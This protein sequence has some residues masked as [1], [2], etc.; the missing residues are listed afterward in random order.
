MNE[1]DVTI[2]VADVQENT[3]HL[4]ETTMQQAA[5]SRAIVKNLN[6]KR[7]VDLVVLYNSYY[8]EHSVKEIAHMLGSGTK[9]VAAAQ[10]RLL[11]NT[12]STLVSMSSDGA[13]EM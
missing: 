1:G 4:A 12:R 11:N 5:I 8:Q 3:S 10:E 9:T 6:P 2:N 7:P 13:F